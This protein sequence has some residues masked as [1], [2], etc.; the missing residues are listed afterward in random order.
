MQLVEFLRGQLDHRSVATHKASDLIEFRAE[1][2]HVEG[3]GTQCIVQ[4][5]VF[6]GLDVL[7]LRGVQLLPVGCLQDAKVEVVLSSHFEVQ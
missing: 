7:L 6:V 4:Q 3:D 5:L 1:F 2:E